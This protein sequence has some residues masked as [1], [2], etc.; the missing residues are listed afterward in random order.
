MV[1]LAVLGVLVSI[2]IPYMQDM[3]KNWRITTQTNEL[4]ADLTAARGQAAARSVTVTVCA[5]AD[6][7]TCSEDWT[8]G[9]IVFT[10]ANSDAT[11]D[12]DDAILRVAPALG[13]GPTLRVANLSVPGRVQ[14]RPTGAAAGVTG[15]GATFTFCDD[16]VGDFG[17]TV[18]VLPTGRAVA[19]RSACP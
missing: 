3:V 4:L 14:F 18:T 11:R 6:G 19:S 15:G 16:R 2:S 17:R 1:V 12:G 13:G 8:Q 10:D 5:S 7:L 9:R